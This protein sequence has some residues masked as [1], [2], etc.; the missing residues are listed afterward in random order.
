MRITDLSGQQPIRKS[1]YELLR[2]L[3]CMMVIFLHYLGRGGITDHFTE[4]TPAIVLFGT[5]VLKCLCLGA[6]NQF[7]LLTGFFRDNRVGGAE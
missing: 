6:V 7:I 5:T 4:S 1:N 2:L 3:S